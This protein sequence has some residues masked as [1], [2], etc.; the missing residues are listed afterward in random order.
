MR[1]R[2]GMGILFDAFEYMFAGGCLLAM[3][4]V[5]MFLFGLLRNL[6]ALLKAAREGLREFLILTYRAYKPIVAHLQPVTQRYLG[7]QIGG[8]PARVLCTAAL[9]LLVLLVIDLLLRWRVSVFF[10]ALAILHGAIVGF[11]WD[12]LDQGAEFRTGERIQ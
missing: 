6:P 8:A 7:I 9:S 4:F 5:W 10:S 3:N 2:R 12:E 1:S 11:L